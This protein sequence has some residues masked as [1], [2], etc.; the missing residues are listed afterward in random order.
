MSLHYHH[1]RHA[2][3]TPEPASPCPW[4][5]APPFPFTPVQLALHAVAIRAELSGMLATARAL[6]ADLHASLKS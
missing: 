6:R 1:P 5:S 2:Y 3:P 4:N